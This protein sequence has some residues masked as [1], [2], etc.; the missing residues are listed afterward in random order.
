MNNI[1]HMR[2]TTTTTITTMIYNHQ[3]WNIAHEEV[4]LTHALCQRA[5]NQLIQIFGYLLKEK[6]I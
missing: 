6:L 3:R 5:Y 4:M 1:V 2:N